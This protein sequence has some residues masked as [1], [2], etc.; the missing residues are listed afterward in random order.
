MTSRYFIALVSADLLGEGE[1]TLAESVAKVLDSKR[2]TLHGRNLKSTMVPRNQRRRKRSHRRGGQVRGGSHR[3]PVA[4]CR[5][6]LWQCRCAEIDCLSQPIN[7]VI[8]SP[9]MPVRRLGQER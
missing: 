5:H 3:V 2:E 7:P 4:N 1:K 6:H 8:W 9:P